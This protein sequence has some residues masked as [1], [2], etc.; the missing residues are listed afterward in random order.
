MTGGGRFSGIYVSDNDNINVSLKKG[1]R[2]I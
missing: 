1:S 2:K